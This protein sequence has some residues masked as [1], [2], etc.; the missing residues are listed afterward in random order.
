MYPGLPDPMPTHW[1]AAGNALAAARLVPFL[2]QVVPALA[3]APS[4]R[5]ETKALPSPMRMVS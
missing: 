3:P 1:N 5:A 4:D 2:R